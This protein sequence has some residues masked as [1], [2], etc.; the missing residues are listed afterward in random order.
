MKVLNE[1]ITL[2][3]MQTCVREKG[4][5]SFKTFM[6]YKGAIGVDDTELISV[7]ETAKSL[8]ALVTAHCEHGDAV[9]A[10]QQRFLKQGKTH[11]RY[12]AQSRPAPVEGEATN[13]AIMLAR[14]TGEPIYI[15]HVTCK[16]ALDAIAEARRRGQFVLAETCPQYLLLDDSVYEKP[17]FEGAA[18]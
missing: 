17:N 18:Y 8:G 4:I 16:E 15:V 14:L 5:P 1:G 13:R 6:A 10:L 7:M 12:H 9:V 2:S 11:A 3:E